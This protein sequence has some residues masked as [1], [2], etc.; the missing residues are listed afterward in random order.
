MIQMTSLKCIALNRMMTFE[1]FVWGWLSFELVVAFACERSV[2]S[3]DTD[4]KFQLRCTCSVILPFKT[5]E[6]TKEHWI[7]NFR[8]EIRQ[9]DAEKQGP[10]R[11]VVAKLYLDSAYQSWLLLWSLITCCWFCRSF[12]G[13]FLFAFAVCPCDPYATKAVHI[14]SQLFTCDSPSQFWQHDAEKQGPFRLLVAKLYL[15][16]AYQSWL[17]LWSLVVHSVVVFSVVFCLHLPFALV[18]PY[19]TK[20]VHICSQLFTCD[21]PSQF[22]QH[23]AEKQG[24]FRLL[25][26]KLYLILLTKADCCCDHLLSILS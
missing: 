8:S 24:P 21:S 20:A 13:C 3:D 7:S 15:D 12:L 26:A 14:C 23:D 19:A 5:W 6:A 4:D 11:L 25:V 10:F 22:W 17:L 1:A 18:T 16:S 9:H 2:S